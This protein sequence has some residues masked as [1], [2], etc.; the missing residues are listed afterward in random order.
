MCPLEEKTECL[1]ADQWNKLL[2]VDIDD[3]SFLSQLIEEFNNDVKIVLNY[4]NKS[5][6]LVGE[7]KMVH[8]VRFKMFKELCQELTMLG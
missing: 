2:H 1:L 4:E 7:E 6:T 8:K 5:I 3:T